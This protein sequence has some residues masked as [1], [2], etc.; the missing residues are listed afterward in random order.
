MSNIKQKLKQKLLSKWKLSLED[1]LLL[2][3][4]ESISE[5]ELMVKL[6]TKKLKKIEDMIWK[7]EEKDLYWTATE[8]ETEQLEYLVWKKKEII[9]KIKELRWDKELTINDFKQKSNVDILNFE[10][11]WEVMGSVGDIVGNVVTDIWKEI[12]LDSIIDGIFDS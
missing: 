9:N 8:E 4:I 10:W 11:F 6:L 1:K 7:I 5:E 12:A 2:D 3:K